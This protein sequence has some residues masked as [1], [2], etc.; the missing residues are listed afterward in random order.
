[1]KGGR[2][3]IERLK[4]AARRLGRRR[5]RR[6]QGRDRAYRRDRAARPG[7][8]RLGAVDRARRAPRRLGDPRAADAA[9]LAAHRPSR[10]RRSWRRRSAS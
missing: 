2:Q 9:D 1:M 6:R 3:A 4:G 10:D 8:L 5:R 7:E